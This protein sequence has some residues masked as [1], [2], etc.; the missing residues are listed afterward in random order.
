[1]RFMYYIKCVYINPKH[2]MQYA[3]PA[4]IILN[5]QDGAFFFLPD[6]GKRRETF[7]HFKKYP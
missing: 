6:T 3:I 5:K 7:F 4:G 2:K 1:M